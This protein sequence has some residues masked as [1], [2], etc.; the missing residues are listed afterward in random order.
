MN[1]MCEHYNYFSY[2]YNTVTSVLVMQ[3]ALFYTF[4]FFVDIKAG[5]RIIYLF[6]WKLCY[7][8]WCSYLIKKNIYFFYTHNVKA[9][10]MN[11][12]NAFR[13]WSL[14]RIP[15]ILSKGEEFSGNCPRNIIVNMHIDGSKIA[16]SHLQ[17]ESVVYKAR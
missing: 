8:Y 9:K 1:I 15:L 12:H 7:E 16:H 6:I 11:W 10:V 5:T 14:I 3:L 13:Q 2:N 17:G 4:H